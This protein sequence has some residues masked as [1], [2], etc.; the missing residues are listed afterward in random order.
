M[1]CTSG[2]TGVD[3]VYEKPDHPD[4]VLK[5][6]EWTVSECVDRIVDLLVKHVRLCACTG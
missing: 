3:S 5:S 1:L 2:F 6:G 4:L